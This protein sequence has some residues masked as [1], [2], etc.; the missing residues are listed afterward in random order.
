MN[1]LLTDRMIRIAAGNLR[2]IEWHEQEAGRLEQ[3][4]QLRRAVEAFK[5]QARGDV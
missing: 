1:A 3:V 2:A 4:E 5:A